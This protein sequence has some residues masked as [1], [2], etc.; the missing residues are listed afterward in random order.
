MTDRSLVLCL[1]SDSVHLAWLPSLWGHSGQ[2]L[3]CVCG[4]LS[5][6]ALTRF[7]GWAIPRGRLGSTLSVSFYRARDPECVWWWM[8]RLQLPRC[9]WGSVITLAYNR[10]SCPPSS[11]SLGAN[12][13]RRRIIKTNSR[14]RRPLVKSPNRPCLCGAIRSG[15]EHTVS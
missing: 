9:F 6:T 12:C 5:V 3:L 4:P 14:L 1:H 7:P 13:I 15:G 2:D 10:A 8:S 11:P